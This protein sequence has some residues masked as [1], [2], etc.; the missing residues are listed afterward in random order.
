MTALGTFAATT[1]RG[2]LPRTAGIND[3]IFLTSAFRATHKPPQLI[4][5]AQM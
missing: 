3:S 5:L 1:N 2:A 4:V